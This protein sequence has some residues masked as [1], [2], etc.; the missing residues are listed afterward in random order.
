MNKYCTHC[1]AILSYKSNNC[2][3]CGSHHIKE[4]VINIQKQPTENGD[5]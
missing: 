3:L 4:I 2:S 5:K 1:C